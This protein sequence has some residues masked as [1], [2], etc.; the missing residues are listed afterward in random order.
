MLFGYTFHNQAKRYSGTKSLL[1]LFT[2]K[3]PQNGRFHQ[4]KVTVPCASS[5]RKGVKKASK[6]TLD[7]AQPFIKVDFEKV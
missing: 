1:H 4:R 7:L 2:L 6:T 3:T 5:M